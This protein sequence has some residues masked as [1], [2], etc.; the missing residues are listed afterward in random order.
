MVMRAGAGIP[1]LLAALMTTKKELILLHS[2]VNLN[3]LMIAQVF[4]RTDWWE[5]FT[6]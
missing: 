4:P 2:P 6:E 1:C 3:P 5:D